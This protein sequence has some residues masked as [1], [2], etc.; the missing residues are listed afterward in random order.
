M[1]TKG[2]AR[3]S[4]GP[5]EI[6]RQNT[7]AEL[8]RLGWKESRLQ[9]SPEWRVPDTPHDLTKRE[10]GQSFKTC[11]QADLVAFA[12]DSAQPHALQIIFE[13]KEPTIEQG[14]DQLTRYLASEPVVRMGYWTNG[15]SSLALYKS[16][17]NDWIEVKDA[18][19]PN[20]GDDF[21]APPDHPPTWA[22]LR[23]PTQ[24]QLSTALTRLV[25]TVVASDSRS[26]RREDQLRE[27]LHVLL[28][29]VESDSIASSKS[30]RD[31]P[32]SFRIYGDRTTMVKLTSDEIQKQ[33]KNYFHKQRNRVFHQDDQEY[34]R[35]T[36]ATIFAVV[37][38]LAPW[39]ILG[40]KV[41]LL[42]KAFQMFRTQA[43]KS[44]EGQFL[45]PQRI[46]RP[47][48][49]AM[50]IS[51]DDKVID[52]ACGTGGFLIEALRQVQDR[53]FESDETWRLVKF[54]N[55]GLYGVDMDPIGV[56]L[57]RA[58]MISMQD[59]STHTLVGD[60]V[61]T[62]IWSGQFPQLQQELGT[63]GKNGVVE[64]QF[65]VV[66]TNP[67]FGEDL[68]VSAMD[69]R[70]SGYTIT[71]AAAS[72]SRG[73][74]N[75]HVG[76]EIGLIYLELSYRLLQIGGRVGIVLPETYFFSHKYRWL[77][78]WLDGRFVLRGMLNIPME[79]F[80]EFCRAKT[81]FYI[82]EKVGHG[83]TFV[84]VGYDTEGDS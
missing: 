64:G 37:D 53:E 77:P 74:K 17:S 78:D 66:L 11:G 18:P 6:V 44:G 58:M 71:K 49:M 43:L 15:I 25:A 28:V 13:F 54:A 75:T 34:I 12:D 50:D 27:L 10:R 4:L 40:D 48:V 29:K 60:S 83:E 42:A 57:T 35:L 51:S 19:L 62:H 73:Q 3:H 39:R 20:P 9:W 72:A 76:L 22:D 69:A 33:F 84:E 14:R 63:P 45:T 31:K 41:D 23:E 68:K 36:D 1:A 26:V 52:P 82:F 16:H 7:V 81:N 38:T 32:V 55:D 46:V 79:A 70:Y 30:N 21:T 56:K 5:E 47:C 59:G 2:E 80:E 61:R 24:A 67:P 8:K 65:T